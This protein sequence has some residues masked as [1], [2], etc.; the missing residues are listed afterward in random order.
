MK[1]KMHLAI[2]F[3]SAMLFMLIDPNT[4]QSEERPSTTADACDAKLRS[5]MSKALTPKSKFDTATN[6]C[7]VTHLR[8]QNTSQLAWSVDR[9]VIVTSSRPIVLGDG[10]HAEAYGI[11]FSPDIGDARARP[12]P[13]KSAA[14]PV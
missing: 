8:F 5:L 3:I 9:L 11:R 4:A 1:Y 10:L 14:T 12:L 7:M 6:I 2:L 13:Y